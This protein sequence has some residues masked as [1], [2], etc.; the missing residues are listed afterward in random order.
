MSNIYAQVDGNTVVNVIVAD[1]PRDV[2]DIDVTNV[3]VP[4]GP[5]WSW[6]GNTFSPPTENRTPLDPAIPVTSPTWVK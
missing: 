2:N 3:P 5:G 1:A 4:P 6:D